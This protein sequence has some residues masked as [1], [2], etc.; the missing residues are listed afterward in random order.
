MGDYAKI[1]KKKPKSL[2]QAAREG[3]TDADIYEV[4][5]F[6]KEITPEQKANVLSSMVHLDYMFFERDNDMCK[7]EN[8]GCSI[9]LFNCFIYG[10]VCPCTLYLSNNSVVAVKR[11]GEDV[12]MY[13]QFLLASDSPK[14]QHQQ[15]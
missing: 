12:R 2:G 13:I 11:V 14:N 1:T 9:V 5:F 6:A 10:C 4:D 3:F 15:V 8:D 7:Y